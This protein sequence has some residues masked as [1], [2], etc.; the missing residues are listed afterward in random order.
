MT[1]R[2]AAVPAGVA[3]TLAALAFIAIATV[4]LIAMSQPTAARQT[5][6][7]TPEAPASCDTIEWKGD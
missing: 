7:V 3:L 2:R 4:V 6:A 5:G 1:G